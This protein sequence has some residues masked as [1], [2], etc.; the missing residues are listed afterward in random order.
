MFG[1][2]RVATR[3][4]GAEGHLEAT[5]AQRQAKVVG[6]WVAKHEIGEGLLEIERVLIDRGGFVIRAPLEA[7]DALNEETEPLIDVQVGAECDA[8]GEGIYRFR[9]RVGRRR[10]QGC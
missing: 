2:A 5:P 3:R 9:S 1:A 8:L 6:L 10:S 4:A 7:T